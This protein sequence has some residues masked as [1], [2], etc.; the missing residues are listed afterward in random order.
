M[1]IGN[2]FLILKDR[3]QRIA[4][5]EFSAKEITVKSI[6]CIFESIKKRVKNECDREIEINFPHLNKLDCCKF[7]IEDPLDWMKDSTMTIVPKDN[8]E[9]IIELFKLYVEKSKRD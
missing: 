1:F 9:Y 7:T 5:N 4:W 8:D 6:L 3:I 2:P